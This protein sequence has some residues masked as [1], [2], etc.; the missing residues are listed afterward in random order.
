[1][2]HIAKTKKSLASEPICAEILSFS[3]KVTHLKMCV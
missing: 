3:L 2:Y 1:M